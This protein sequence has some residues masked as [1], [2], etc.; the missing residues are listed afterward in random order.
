MPIRDR[1]ISLGTSARRENGQKMLLTRVQKA[2][3]P[4]ND[5]AMP[6]VAVV[7]LFFSPFFANPDQTNSTHQAAR[8]RAVTEL[9]FFASVGDVKRINRIV[10]MWKM[11]VKAL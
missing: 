9:M 10:N 7:V 8:R 3:L 6:V 11:K 1:R 2:A 5:G 4:E